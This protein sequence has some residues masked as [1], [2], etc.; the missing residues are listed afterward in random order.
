M[1]IY[2][3]YSYSSIPHWFNLLQSD[4][5]VTINKWWVIES[6]SLVEY[7]KSKLFCS[8]VE[9]ECSKTL[10]SCNT[11]IDPD[12]FK[13]YQEVSHLLKETSDISSKITFQ[14]FYT[15]LRSNVLI[16][17]LN[18]SDIGKITSEINFAHFCKIPVI[19]I[20]HRCFIEPLI[21]NKIN[22]LTSTLNTKEIVRLILA[23]T[24]VEELFKT[25]VSAPVP[26]P[27]PAPNT[28]KAEQAL[29][30]YKRTCQDTRLTL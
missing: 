13:P 28:A 4:S 6:I 17:D 26:A 2:C 10:P 21:H 20:N 24:F 25:P 12:L 3:S 30:S 14:Q 1:I 16:A 23:F 9:Q 7:Y 19:G 11:N 8:A 29:D 18:S 22:V 5:Y 15:I 27:V